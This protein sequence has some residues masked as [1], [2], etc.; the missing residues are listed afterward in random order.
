MITAFIIVS[1]YLTAWLLMRHLKMVDDLVDEIQTVPNRWCRLILGI[2][3]I[4]ISPSIFLFLVML[5]GTVSV[6]EF[7]QDIWEEK[8][9]ES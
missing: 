9:K 1:L 7:F 2:F 3:S 4:I 6:I 5:S 8:Q